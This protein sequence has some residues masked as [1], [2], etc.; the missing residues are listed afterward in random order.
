M[1]GSTKKNRPPH[2]TSKQRGTYRDDHGTPQWLCDTV[3]QA[4]RMPCAFDPA[5]SVEANKLVGAA[6]Y[7]TREDDAI[8]CAWPDPS[9]CVFGYSWCN[10]PGPGGLTRQFWSLWREWL[11][12]PGAFLF[13]QIDHMRH[14]TRPKVKI[15]RPKIPTGVV[16]LY[17][18]LK[19]H[20]QK[21]QA[22]WPSALVVSHPN[23]SELVR[24]MKEL[25]PHGHTLAWR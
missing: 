2:L 6:H 25:S 23:R 22:S 13:Y 18:R 15:L 1:I 17:K 7:L 14:G 9:E 20:G 21:N 11:K 12:T 4:M 8:N 24:I 5:S 16:L 19:F 3:R 10:P